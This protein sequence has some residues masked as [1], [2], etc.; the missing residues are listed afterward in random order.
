ML[1]IPSTVPVR[2]LSVD[3]YQPDCHEAQGN[4]HRMSHTDCIIY[5]GFS[6]GYCDVAF[7]GLQWHPSPF[8][9]EC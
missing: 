5:K 3:M 8:G 7:V 1:G 6:E 4:S 9:V 2:T